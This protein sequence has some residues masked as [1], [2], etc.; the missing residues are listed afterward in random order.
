MRQQAQLKLNIGLKCFVGGVKNAQSQPPQAAQ[1]R[2]NHH[3]RG[4]R[5]VFAVLFQVEK[6]RV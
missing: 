2:Q 4:K 6:T 3:A 1:K 5:L